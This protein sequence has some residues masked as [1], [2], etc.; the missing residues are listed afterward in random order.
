MVSTSR[1]A[2]TI[3]NVSPV[4]RSACTQCSDEPLSDTDNSLV[5]LHASSEDIKRNLVSCGGAV[6]Y[7]DVQLIQSRITRSKSREW[8]IGRDPG[9]VVLAYE[10]RDGA[11]SCDEPISRRGKSWVQ[12]FTYRAETG[13]VDEDRLA[14]VRRRGRTD[15]SIIGGNHCARKNAWV[16]IQRHDRNGA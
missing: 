13:A 5:A 2:Q 8:D 10:N 16:T 4:S 3:L 12:G 14:P 1:S 15:D 11:L 9:T 7:L 6:R